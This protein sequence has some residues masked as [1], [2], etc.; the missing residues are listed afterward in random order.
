ML[1]ILMLLMVMIIMVITVMIIVAVVAFNIIQNVESGMSVPS[2]FLP[3]D[4]NH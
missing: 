1:M 4:S 2:L 3:V